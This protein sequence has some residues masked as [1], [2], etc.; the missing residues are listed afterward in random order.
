MKKYIKTLTFVCSTTVL[1]AV[2][3]NAFSM[4]STEFKINTIESKKATISNVKLLKDD[5]SYVIK[6][7]VHSKL[8]NRI[9]PIP[10]HVDISVV[11]ADGK[12][13]NTS[14][15]SI[16]R[17]SRKSRYARFEL[18]LKVTPSTGNTIRVAHHNAPL[19]VNATDLEHK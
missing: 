8:K 14:P 12:T 10:G 1:I 2:S 16:H 9:T 11:G 4:E 19:G 15:V 18:T 17:V 13:I 3:G 5:G 6:G 7:K